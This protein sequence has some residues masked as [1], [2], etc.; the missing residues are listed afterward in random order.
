MLDK[1]NNLINTVYEMLTKGMDIGFNALRE[2]IY[3]I[4]KTE[5]KPR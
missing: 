2:H 4:L 1:Q 5:L 3:E